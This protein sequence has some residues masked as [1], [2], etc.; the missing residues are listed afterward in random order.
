MSFICKVCKNEIETLPCPYCGFTGE[1]NTDPH[2][3]EVGYQ[4]LGGQYIIGQVVGAGGFGVTYSAWDCSLK[5]CVA[6]K[7]YMPGEFSTRMPGNSDLTVYGGEKEEQFKAGMYKFYDESVRLAKFTEVPGIVQIYDWFHE[8][9]TAYIVMEFL[10]GETL[11]DRIQ[12]EGKIPVTDAIA[13]IVSVLDALEV[14]HAEGI[15]HR[16][17]APNNIF[18][19]KDGIVKL[20]DF[21]AARSATGTHSKS[22]T[23]LYKEGYT[24]EEQYRSRGEQG[25]WTD[26]YASA[27][28]LYKAITGITPDGAMERRFKDTLKAPGKCGVKVPAHVDAAIMNAL[29]VSIKKRTQSAAKFKSELLSVRGVKKH[30]ERTEEKRA[31]RISPAVWVGGFL[32]IVLAGTL[33]VLQSLGIISFHAEALGNLFVPAGQVRVMNVVNME[34]E[35]AKDRLEKIGLKM[36]IENYQYSNS[37]QKGRIISQDVKKGSIVDEGT[38]ISVI[39]S[40][41]AQSVEIPDLVGMSE[42]KAKEMLD[43]LILETEV[44]TDWNV[45]LPG[46]VYETKPKAGEEILQGGNPVML[47]V[48][49]GLDYHENTTYDVVDV[50]GRNFSDIQQDLAKVGIY[51]VC[52]EEKFDDNV[53]KGVILGQDISEGTTLNAGEVITVVVSKGE[54]MMVVPELVGMTTQEAIDELEK[55]NLVAELEE[56]LIEN[57]ESGI[58]LSQKAEAGT[59]LSKGTN[60]VVVVSRKAKA[61]PSVM[62][63][64][65]E[66]A[67]ALC[68][69]SGIKVTTKDVRSG[70]N[71]VKRQNVKEGEL[72]AEDEALVIEIGIPEQDYDQQYSEEYLAALNNYLKAA[73]LPTVVLN[74]G[75]SVRNTHQPLNESATSL[76]S[77]TAGWI[78]DNYEYSTNVVWKNTPG[79]YTI[80]TGVEL[81]FSNSGV[82]V[83]VESVDYY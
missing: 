29:N 25:P 52:G 40:H 43:D 3:L 16:D 6:I 9:N 8:N 61:M 44:T 82:S 28:T 7:E 38:V 21:G 65:K 26:V 30:F 73:N 41:D 5:R 76:A 71:T 45:T 70:N 4:L 48:S 56:E 1:E 83:T 35:E 67:V 62:G 17:I 36:E 37:V 81:A 33:L 53:E 31:G 47:Y 42:E 66:E 20:L 39:V 57:E 23:V 2:Y 78:K 54:E 14:V 77:R 80:V 15:I 34:E 24:A 13:V 12:R 63:L 72:L 75:G 32:G 58:V 49:K 55:R 19:T 79:A 74:S 22:L 68:E 10:E 60:V 59:E 18:I 50:K 46:T 51:L 11:E 64:S 27:A 69:K